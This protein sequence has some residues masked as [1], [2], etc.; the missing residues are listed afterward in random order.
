MTFPSR[1]L[2]AYL[3]CSRSSP[4][5][6]EIPRR[7]DS[8]GTQILVP[9][10]TNIIF[11]PRTNCLLT[12]IEP[13]TTQTLSV[14]FFVYQHLTQLP[15]LKMAYFSRSAKY[16]C[17]TYHIIAREPKAKA[18]GTSGSA[19]HRPPSTPM[20]SRS[21]SST[22]MTTLK[23]S[24]VRILPTLT[25]PSQTIMLFKAHRALTEAPKLLPRE[26]PEQLSKNTSKTG[27][28]GM[29][30]SNVDIRHMKME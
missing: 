7:G 16:S 2:L 17:P 19:R 26:T 25:M 10:T 13:S 29:S 6:Q 3:Q 23:L 15:N 9:K 12:Y 27:T 22:Q 14:H 4:R 1:H 21:N 28:M 18:S 5:M 11:L 24:S 30:R 20:G 8:A